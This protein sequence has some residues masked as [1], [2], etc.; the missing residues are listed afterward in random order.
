MANNDLKVSIGIN[1]KQFNAEMKEMNKDLREAQKQF[2]NTEKEMTLL[3]NSEESVAKATKSLNNVQEK[4]SNILKSQEKRIKELRDAEMSLVKSKND[5]AKKIQTVSAKY[6]QAKKELGENAKETKDYEK[7]LKELNTSLGK[8]DKSLTSTKKNINSLK[9]A[10][11]TTQSEIDVTAAKMENLGKKSESSTKGASSKGGKAATGMVV[12]DAAIAVA[13]KVQEPFDKAK[14]ATKDLITNAVEVNSGLDKMAIGLGKTGEEADN[15]K[16]RVKSLFKDGYNME[17]AQEAVSVT[18]K[19]MGDMLSTDQLDVMSKKLAAMNETLGADIPETALVAEKMMKNFGISGNEALDIITTGFQQGMD[20]DFL[21]TLNEYGS[22]FTALGLNAQD[23]FELIQEGSKRGVFN[24]DQL[25]DAVRECGIKMRE[26]DDNSIKALKSIG[27]N[28]KTVQANISKGGE[29]AKKQ[30]VEL[31]KKIAAIKDPVK[32]NEVAVAVFGTKFEDI[33]K[34]IIES[35]AGVDGQMTDLNGNIVDTTGKSGELTDSL[36]DLK[37][38]NGEKTL[39]EIKSKLLELGEKMMPIFD[40]LIKVV[41]KIVEFID[42]HPS[43]MNAI[44][45]ILPLLTVLGAVLGLV[46]NPIGLIMALVGA[47]LIL[48]DIMIQKWDELIEWFKQKFNGWC[49]W[50]NENFPNVTAILKGLVGFFVNVDWSEAIGV[51][52]D[53][54]TSGMGSIFEALGIDVPT[55]LSTLLSTFTGFDWSTVWDG[56]K[57]AF[58]TMWSYIKTTFNPMSLLKG[59]LGILGG[60][61]PDSALPEPQAISLMSLNLDSDFMPYAAVGR[62]IRIAEEFGHI[63]GSMTNAP[64]KY[65]NSNNNDMNIADLLAQLVANTSKPVLAPTLNINSPTESSVDAY[66]KTKNMLRDLAKII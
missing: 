17:S 42:K 60:L 11:K 27:L 30:M 62:G 29:N 48:L 40:M 14:E 21:D 13:E 66:R 44:R 34:D 32:Q 63:E 55:L 59:G 5:L 20:E 53:T 12:A 41:D 4:Q 3:E 22:T 24:T 47:L 36:D 57:N 58:D 2:A 25:A 64:N 52:M 50:M 8:V 65:A 6:E 33:G 23:S 7:K 35:V 46:L 9:S 15:T 61:V 56:V 1:N 19:L 39:N 49:D 26:M 43:I 45:D 51:W 37:K 10:M 28:S 54:L 16:N 31:A 18:Q 38:S